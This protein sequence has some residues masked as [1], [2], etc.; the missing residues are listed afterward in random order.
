MRHR[1]W[2]EENLGKR[3]GSPTTSEIVAALRY[4]PPGRRLGQSL[5]R[6]PAWEG[7]VPYKYRLRDTACGIP[8]AV[9]RRG[10]TFGLQ[11]RP[12]TGGVGR[13]GGGLPMGNPG[14]LHQDPLRPGGLLRVAGRGAG[15]RRVVGRGRFRA[16][17]GRCAAPEGCPPGPR[18][19]PAP[20]GRGD[21][22]FL[23]ALLLHGAREHRR[24]GGDTALQRPGVRRGP[25]VAVL[26]R[27][28]ERPQ[29]PRALAND[30]RV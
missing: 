19:S 8:L 15:L 30:L 3:A 21:R 1:L 7:S 16:R 25:G 20:R 12:D 13:R 22:G 2:A 24:D 5:P 18:L 6:G 28:A 17:D 23:P 10:G 4:P 9:T 29:G 26:A 11:Q 27:T 14:L